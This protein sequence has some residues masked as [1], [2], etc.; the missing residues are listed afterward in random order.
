MN[1]ISDWTRK[2]NIK[3]GVT[4]V[5]TVTRITILKTERIKK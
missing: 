2:E 5:A 4:C 1:K 3:R